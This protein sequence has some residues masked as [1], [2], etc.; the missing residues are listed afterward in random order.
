[1]M[2][3]VADSLRLRSRFHFN[4]TASGAITLPAKN[5][6][7]RRLFWKQ[8]AANRLANFG[9]RVDVGA[10][11]PHAAGRLDRRTSNTGKQWRSPNCVLTAAH[12]VTRMA[13]QKLLGDELQ[14]ESVR[15]NAEGRQAV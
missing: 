11:P 14:A 6:L 5:C 7:T 2:F 3:C 8:G 12:G 10:D 13:A 15:R 1:M 4:A 9:T